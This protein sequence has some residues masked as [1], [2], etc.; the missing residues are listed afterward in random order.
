MPVNIR[1]KQ[2]VTVAERLQLF[3]EKYGNGAIETELQFPDE[4]TVRC[5]AKVT[6]D[7]EK[8][9]RFFTGHAEEKRN[10]TTIN[11]TN[12]TENVESSAVGRA[13][14]MAGFGSDESIASADEV[15]NAL[16]KQDLVEKDEPF[17]DDETAYDP[18][19]LKKT[20][21]K[22]GKTHQGKFPKCLACW[23]AEK[24]ANA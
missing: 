7:V 6:L 8:P 24:E 12:A 14:A 13:L 22:C 1:G 20:C 11:R 23:K 10:S 4:N 18:E 5:K 15:V 21:P 19:P 17:P 16:S 2:Y 9:A 3:H